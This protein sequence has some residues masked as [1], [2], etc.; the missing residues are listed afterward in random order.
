MVNKIAHVKLLATRDDT[1]SNYAFQDL[2]TGLFIMCT[3]LPNWK[4]PDIRIG[5]SGFLE[6]QTVKA[7]DEY[8][9]P[10]LEQTIRYQYSN[11]YLINFIQKTDILQNNEIIL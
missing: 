5:D 1:Y 2:E 4:I 9:N 11:V 7:G 6:Y 10:V 8:Y 3:R